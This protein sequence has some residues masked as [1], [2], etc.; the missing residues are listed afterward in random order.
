VFATGAALVALAVPGHGLALTQSGSDWAQFHFNSVL[1]GVTPETTIGSG[2]A[3]T[4]TTLWT[5]ALPAGSFNSPAVVQDS[6]GTDLV[7]VGDS[8]GTF[9]AYNAATG[10]QVWSANLGTKAIDSSPAVVNGTVYVA[11]QAGTLFALNAV[12]GATQ[13]S[14]ALASGTIDSSPNVVSAPDG[15]G[16]LA[17]LGSLKGK[18][19]AIYGAGNSHGQCK[20][21]WTFTASSFP[22]TWASPGYGTDAQGRH[23]VVIGS[24]DLDDSVYS[25]NVANGAMIW[26]HQTSN[27]TD[28]DVGGGATISAPGNNGFADGVVYIEG[29]TGVVYALDLTTG[30]VDWTFTVGNPGAAASTGALTGNTLVIGSDNGVYGINATTGAELWHALSGAVL[31]SPAVSGAAGKQ[32]AFVGTL[33]GSLY[34]LAVATGKKIWTAPGSAGGYNASPAVSRGR[35]FD[36]NLAGQLTAYALPAAI[37]H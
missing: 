20:V 21:D 1:G 16:P 9:F 36:V 10:A 7:Y 11:T 32:V 8:A 13:C 14:I 19:W 5:T 17:L 28:Q 22:G 4:L 33:K 12:T 6:A 30:S 26:R 25:I 37:R 35:V 15:S 24:K 27:I 34:G 29:K 31:A 3:K 2:N 18:F 23:V